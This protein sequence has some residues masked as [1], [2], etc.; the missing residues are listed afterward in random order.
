MPVPDTIPKLRGLGD[1]SD[2]VSCVGSVTLNAS[3]V[4]SISQGGWARPGVAE[5]GEVVLDAGLGL[6]LIRART[7]A[8]KSGRFFPLGDDAG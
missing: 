5:L 7:H 8:L 2:R 1:V 3:E 4:F 6:V